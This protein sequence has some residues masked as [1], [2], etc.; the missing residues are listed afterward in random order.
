MIFV[1]MVNTSEFLFNLTMPLPALSD[2]VSR[3][4]VIASTDGTINRVL[5]ATIGGVIKPG[6]PIVELIPLDDT[7]LIEAE[8]L[9]QD[10]AF[11][12]P[13]QPAR[14]KLTAYGYSRYGSLDAHVENISADAIMNDQKQSV[15]VI[16][17][18]SNNSGDILGYIGIN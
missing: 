10:I 13:G 7:L 15:Y 5:V 18:R 17:I 8:V 11:L 3:T 16:K 9:P 6:M 2:K 1:T 4:D 14:V 12:R